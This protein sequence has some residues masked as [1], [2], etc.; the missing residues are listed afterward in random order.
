MPGNGKNCPQAAGQGQAES[1][2]T[3]SDVVGFIDFV[4]IVETCFAWEERA[5]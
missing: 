3:A 2:V 5:C 1:Q 4:R